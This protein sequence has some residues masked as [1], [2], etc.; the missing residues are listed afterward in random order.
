MGTFLVHFS[1]LGVALS[2]VSDELVGFDTPQCMRATAT[3][4][5]G[6]DHPKDKGKMRRE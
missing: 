6:K 4:E 1:K 2:L 5:R 3:Q